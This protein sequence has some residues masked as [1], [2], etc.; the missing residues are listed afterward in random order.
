MN[1]LPPEPEKVFQ[2]KCIDFLQSH[3]WTVLH[4]RPAQQGGRWIT[5]VV[6]DGKGYPDLTIAR[7]RIVWIEFKAEGKYLEPDQKKWRDAILQAGG[8]WY[9][10]RP[11][12][13]DKIVEILK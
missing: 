3:Q 13:W 4:I 1:N 2:K 9:L 12:D 8:E 10:V 5:A 11:S 6:A 7:E